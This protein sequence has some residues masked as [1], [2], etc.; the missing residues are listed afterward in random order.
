L[1]FWV[2]GRAAKVSSGLAL[3]HDIIGSELESRRNRP[4]D[5]YWQAEKVDIEASECEAGDLGVI[6]GGTLMI[7]Q[8]F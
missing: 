8:P 2:G 4:D 3:A 7:P 6:V 1:D 5:D